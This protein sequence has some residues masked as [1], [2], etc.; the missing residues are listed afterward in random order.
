MTDPILEVLSPGLG[1]TFQD[2]GRPGWRRFG[3]PTGGAMDAH[4]A[5]CANRLLGN[6]P[7]ATVVECLMQGARFLVRRD[8]WLALTGADLRASHP[9][10]RVFRAAAGETIRLEGA[11]AGIWA[12]LAVEGGFAAPH[13]L[14]SASTLAAAGLG[15]ALQKGDGL[16]R[17][18]TEPR[19]EMPAGVAARIAHWSEQ[20]D[21]AHPP[22]LRVW[23]GPQ[24]DWFTEADRHRLFHQAWTV[25]AQSNR[26]GYRLSGEPLAAPTRSMI[27]EP[28][29]V[30]S[31]QVPPDGQP[32][33][34]LRDGPTVGGY[35]KIGV[36]EPDDIDWLVQTAPG[37]TIRFTAHGHA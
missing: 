11:A 16:G 25:A 17:C 1:T 35:P 21:Y 14:D 9:R 12:Y 15:R 20:R 2:Q 10:W 36:L 29:R 34:I 33:V 31:L 19:F 37:R 4:A 5:A 8:C 24:S 26:L 7:W 27:S 23:P 30:G 22:P 18:E 13:W 6:P 32:V 3:V 28:V